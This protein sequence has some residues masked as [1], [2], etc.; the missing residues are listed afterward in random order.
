VGRG[1][2]L[3][4]HVILNLIGIGPGTASVEPI[5]GM[6][7]NSSPTTISVGAG[8]WWTI[9]GIIAAAADG[10]VAGRLAGR[11]KESVA[12]WHGL[13]SWGFTTLVI[14]YLLTTALGG[15]TGDQAQ[16]QAARD[17][18]A[19]AIAQ[20]EQTL[21]YY[22]QPN[23]EN[24]AATTAHLTFEGTR[25]QYLAGVPADVTTKIKGEPWVEDWRVMCLP[26][27]M[28][29]QRAL[30]ADYANH[31]ARFDIIAEYLSTTQP[32]SLMVWGRHDVYFDLAET[33]SWMQALPRM[34]AHV[35]D[36]GHL[37][38]ETHSEPALAFMVDFIK[39]T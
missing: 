21:G 30:L 36:G 1:G 24:E 7:N 38:L 6:A 31:I 13:T 23:P 16:V 2:A 39:R 5:S 19:Q 35:L 9:P 11:P 22:S 10:F 20:W 18:A 27:G 14:F 25:D 8:I 4:T 17:R 37:L 26:G 15:L 28:E 12:G 3:V 33:L 32:P 29:T 34:E